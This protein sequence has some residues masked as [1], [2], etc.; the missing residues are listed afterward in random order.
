MM[1]ETEVLLFDIEGTTTNILFVKDVLF[2]YAR[3]N[4]RKFL[5]EN[6]EVPEIKAAI[7]ELVDLSVR[8]G[9]P[10]ERSGDKEIFVDSIV[11]NVHQQISQDRKTK[12]LKNL[13]GKI[14][15]VA[16]ESGAIK[17][18]VYDDV[19]RKFKEWKNR[20]YK[21]YIYSSGSVE[22]QKLLFG[23]SEYGN[24]LDLL[25]G[26]FDTNVGHKQESQSY[27]TI[28]KEIN[29]EPKKILFFSDIPGEVVAAEKAGMRVVILDRP[30]NPTEL[31]GEIREK[32]KVAK[33][34]DDVEL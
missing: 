32:F 17:G 6:F 3:N 10:I 15:K 16:F 14:W 9:I 30:N 26:H 23:N 34:F 33:T 12:E 13:Q 18:H 4:C 21:L 7:D 2:P 22:A 28:A 27:M 8:D 11:A 20:G 19:P 25:S 31:G 24:L 1:S 5:V 29:V